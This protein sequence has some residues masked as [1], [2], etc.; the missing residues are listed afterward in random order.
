VIGS[1]SLV[2]NFAQMPM[3][4]YQIVRIEGQVDVNGAIGSPFVTRGYVVPALSDSMPG[5]NQFVLNDS[6]RGAFD[7]NFKQVTP[8]RGLTPTEIAAGKELTYTIQFQNTGNA[9]AT[10][11]RI[12]D[13]LDTALNLKTLRLVGSSHPVTRFT[14]L[15]GGLL[16]V[17]FNPIALPDSVSNEPAS[18]GFVSFAIQRNKNYSP[19]Y[20][21]QN[22]A[23]IYFDYNEPIFTNTVKTGLV[24]PTVATSEPDKGKTTAP[25]LLISPNPTQQYF[26]VQAPGGK[27]TGIGE[28]AMFNMEGQVCLQQE[29]A[30]LSKVI[31]VDAGRLPNGAYIVRLTGKTGILSGKVVIQH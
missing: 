2:W 16:E 19:S 17:V 30:D 7:P 26:A 4:T 15:P 9:G 12:T 10:R 28:L 24:S 22:Q 1:D 14:L 11:V 27:L 29:A 6:I 21:I 23:A 5:N 31:R 25:T 13:K 8:A 20:I 3:L 18:H